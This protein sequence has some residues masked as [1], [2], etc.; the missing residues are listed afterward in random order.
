[1]KRLAFALLASCALFTAAPA[2]ATVVMPAASGP[3]IGVFDPRTQ[4]VLLATSSTS[5]TFSTFS[6]IL[7]SAVYRNVGQAFVSAHDPDEAGFFTVAGNPP[8][9]A[10]TIGRDS[11]G[12]L[13]IDFGAIGLSGTENSATYIVR[14][15]AFHFDFDPLGI[16]DGS[17]LS[18]R[19][20]A[21]SGVPE[22]ATWALMIGGFG[23]VGAALRRRRSGVRFVLA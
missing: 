18:G 17:S 12:G 20:F 13:Q 14:A 4:A 22:P 6:A 2:Q 3:I 19:A 5:G 15:D 7:R 10:T 23:M 9:S 16:S 11:T 1:M 8:A 21:A